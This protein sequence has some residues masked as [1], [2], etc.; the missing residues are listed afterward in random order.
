MAKV[1]GIGKQAF[2]SVIENDCFYIDKTSFIKEWWENKPSARRATNPAATYENL[3]YNFYPRPPRGGRRAITLAKPLKAAFLS[4]PSA[5]RATDIIAAYKDAYDIS[6]HA[7]REEGDWA[8]Q[9]H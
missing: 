5:R 2:D 7:L 9:R 6:I 3:A 8:T 1:V 4:T